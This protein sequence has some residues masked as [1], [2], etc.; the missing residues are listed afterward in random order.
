[1]PIISD[2]RHENTLIPALQ[3]RDGCLIYYRQNDF[4]R[5]SKRVD[6][7][8]GE[9]LKVDFKR[10]AYDGTVTKGVKKRIN[11]AVDV[12]LQTT[13][14]RNI[15]NCV[16]GRH[17]D[18]RLGF[19][20][21]TIADQ[22]DWKADK[23]YTHLLKP[24]LRVMKDKHNVK[25]YIWKYELQKRGVVHYHVTIDEFVRH[26]AVNTTWNK[27][28]KKNGL[29]DMYAQKYGHFNPNGT[30]IHK[31]WKIR[32]IGAYLGKYLSKGG[33][34]KN[35]KGKTWDC[36]TDLKRVRF[37]TEVNWE[38]E[39]KVDWMVRHGQA[40]VLNYE[41]YT[42]IKCDHPEKIL[43]EDQKIDYMVWKYA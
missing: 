34:E 15:Y 27:I 21:L 5:P 42:I 7:E 38:N 6:K 1:M 40:T 2:T 13:E 41:K 25:K 43:T 37:S 24:F 36:S 22:C 8:T 33:D 17:M 39:S 16:T 29:S 23:C 20:T 10:K 12:F 26:D 31:V 14:T 35:V 32:N 4:R 30:D 28:Q 3:V 9:V 11:S 19:M 18:F